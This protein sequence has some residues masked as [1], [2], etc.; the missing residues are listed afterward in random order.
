[1]DAAKSEGPRH[2]LHIRGSEGLG[3]ILDQWDP[4]LLARG[5][6]GTEIGALPVKMHQDHSL[7]H[8][9][10]RYSF[11]KSLNEEARIHVPREFIAIDE[12]RRGP[13][14]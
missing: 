9:P 5:N 4:V 13:L 12:D 3:G 1:M 8:L 7:R 11:L 10:K 6:D 14:V 2:T